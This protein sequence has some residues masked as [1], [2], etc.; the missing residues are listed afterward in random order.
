M[1]I[2]W[3]STMLLRVADQA[4]VRSAPSG[5]GR[6]VQGLIECPYCR[7][8]TDWLIAASGA[9]IDVACRCGNRWRIQ[10]SLNQVVALAESQ[11][12]DPRWTCLDDA[13]QALGF[14]RHVDTARGLRR[15]G[16]HQHR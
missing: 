8:V 5:D 16:R 14:T 6:E 10:A 3:E 7:R 15:R 4:H 13:R 12:M 2:G 1:T 11:P 9:Q